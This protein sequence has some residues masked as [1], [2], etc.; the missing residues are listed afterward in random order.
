[1]RSRHAAVHNIRR[2][3]ANGLRHLLR[4]VGFGAVYVTYRNAVLFPLMVIT[5]KLPPG[6]PSAANDVK[7]YSRRIDA[8]GRL[9][10]GVETGIAISFRRF[11]SCH[12]CQEIARFLNPLTIIGLAIYI[13]A[14]LCYILAL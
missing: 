3:T 10:T 11:G 2:Y 7:L 13:F 6:D 4:A 1:M 9:A 5:R 14:A 8:L 12:R